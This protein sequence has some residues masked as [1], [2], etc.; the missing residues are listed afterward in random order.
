MSEQQVISILGT[1][2]ES[3]SVNLLGISGTS[4]RWVNG[5]TVITVNFVN[6]KVAMKTFDKP[7]N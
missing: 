4:S 6:V 7:V 2:T 5:K 3:N 1:P